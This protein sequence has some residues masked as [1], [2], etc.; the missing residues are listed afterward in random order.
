MS[1]VPL[2]TN[3]SI[4]FT[5]VAS[6]FVYSGGSVV[7][8]EDS[9]KDKTRKACK[10]YYQSGIVALAV[11]VNVKIIPGTVRVYLNLILD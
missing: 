5:L 8:C 10:N 7:V 4:N 3:E 1:T 6:S 11:S 2:V 9:L